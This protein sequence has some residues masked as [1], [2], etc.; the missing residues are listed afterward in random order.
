MSRSEYK[1]TLE[2]L[3]ALEAAKGMDFKL[4]RVALA[5]RNLGDPQA[6]FR[7]VHIA[8]TNGKGSVAAMLHSMLGAG[9]Y[10][11]GL[12]TSPHLVDFR[13]RIRVGAERISA[14]EVVAYV[15]EVHAAATVH[16]IQLTF[17]ELVTVLAFMH[18]AR[19]RVDV[20][21]VEVGLGGR[22]D[23]TNVIDPELSVITTI[24]LDHEEY[25]GES[26]AS[27]AAE[28]GGIIKSKRPVILGDLAP[29]AA[30]ALEAIAHE[31]GAPVQRL[32]KDFRIEG[33]THPTYSS[34][35]GKVARLCIAL[36]GSH[37]HRN[38]AVAIAAAE[39]LQSILPL[40]AAAIRGG[41]RSVRWPG[42]LEVVGRNPLVVLDGAHNEAGVET[43]VRELPALV[44][45]RR[46]YLLFGVM[47]DK[48]WRP[49]V[50]LLAPLVDGVVVVRAER[51]R[52]EDPRQ[53][54]TAFAQRCQVWAEETP[55][56]GLARVMQ[57]AGDRGAVVVAGSL[58]L[59]G[60][61]YPHLNL[62]M[63][64]LGAA[65]GGASAQP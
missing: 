16:G 33:E 44:A 2:S 22:L 50:E 46:T 9:G 59:I 12:Y 38:A 26:I 4:E 39:A 20:A 55:A 10:R 49:M 64:K 19:K 58:F 56:A 30:A 47:R 25:L 13:E 11:V 37:Q 63:T 52:G 51:S 65:V 34:A 8:G 42:R 41:L 27:I 61:V 45:G 53:L 24:S 3:Y 57:L 32:G 43:L 5:L 18:F 48:R 17:F 28:K 7:S 1:S 29:E 60:A 36:R 62:P 54:A 23:A 35:R 6:Q 14:D 15:R 31:R 21:V 40:S